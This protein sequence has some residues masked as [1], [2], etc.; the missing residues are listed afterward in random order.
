MCLTPH[1]SNPNLARG[2]QRRTLMGGP[3]RVP[4]DQLQLAT[5]PKV[6]GF[7]LGTCSAPRQSVRAAQPAQQCAD[8]PLKDLQNNK[9]PA[10]PTSPA[11]AAAAPNAYSDTMVSQCNTIAYNYMSYLGGG[12]STWP[13][14]HSGPAWR[15]RRQ[16]RGSIDQRSWRA[17][18]RASSGAPRLGRVQRQGSRCP[19]PPF[20]VPVAP[21]AP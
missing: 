21:Q 4:G 3:V 19:L 14:Q 1:H 15:G 6:W 13:A 11:P 20:H 12:R 18:D 8:R 9:N 7:C 5:P 2:V 16:V 10:D 17:R